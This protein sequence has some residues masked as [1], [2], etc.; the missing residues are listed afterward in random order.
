VFAGL[1]LGLLVLVAW[2]FYDPDEVHKSA[3]ETHLMSIAT[4]LDLYHQDY[5]SF[6][7]AC[8][9]DAQGR[10]M[11]S[12]RVLILPGL[13]EDDLYKEYRFDEPWD[14]PNNR[15][16]AHRMP[17]AYRCPSDPGSYEGQ[18]SYIAP[19][20]PQACWLG[21]K[22]V[23]LSQLSQPGQAI[24]VFEA[25]ESGINW[26]EP[27]DFPVPATLPPINAT[28]GLGVR[29]LH[30][31]GA[32]VLYADGKVE[33]LKATTS[34]TRLSQLFNVPRISIAVEA[35]E[36]PAEAKRGADSQSKV[37]S[38]AQPTD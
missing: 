7:P 5:G 2:L 29:S 8:V 6:P 18:T 22:P 35:P 11:H 4:A 37:L 24:Q 10:P 28:A 31:G 14:G 3:C 30:P 27:R 13:G 19:V 16:L 32:H 26:L 17:D 34:P 20:G 12:W 1:S 36:T 38:P 33:F 23:K 15:R 25:Y 21:A 9:A